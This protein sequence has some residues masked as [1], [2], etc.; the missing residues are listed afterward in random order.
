[1]LRLVCIVDDAS[2]A[3]SRFKGIH[4]L[5]FWIE[6]QH[7]NVL[8]DTGA[9][10]GVLLHNLEVAGIDSCGMDAIALSH[11]HD[12]H[13]GGLAALLQ[14]TGKVDLYANPGIFEE[15][16]SR[17]DGEMRSRGLAVTREEL[18]QLADLHLSAEPQQILPGMYTT[19]TIIDRPEPEGRS[20]HHFVRGPDGW[21]PDPYED[22]MSIVVQTDEGLILV[23]GCCH[24]G[25]L[26]TLRT[27]DMVFEGDVVAILGGMHLG[28]LSDEQLQRIVQV[29]KGYGPPRLYPNHCTGERALAVLAEAFGER[30]T[31]CPAGTEV[32]L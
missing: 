31:H 6:T 15:R 3:E 9:D 19:G 16:F 23:C 22:D 13:T 1:M 4:G 25:L 12:D 24:A 26:N 30:V 28:D 20:A 10:G 11:A 18:E 27:V 8:L 7:G 32:R 14:R 21:A 29:L 5:S 17:R 2:A